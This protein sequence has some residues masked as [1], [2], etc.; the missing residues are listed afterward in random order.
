MTR[1]GILKIKEIKYI[2]FIME[3]SVSTIG[4]S[5]VYEVILNESEGRFSITCT[6]GY[7]Y[8][9]AIEVNENSRGKGYSYKMI[10]FL[11]D[12]TY[13]YIFEPDER[14]FI[15]TDASGFNFWGGKL[16]MDNTYDE[17][18]YENG[19]TFKKLRRVVNKK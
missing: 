4:T 3:Y 6:P 2:Y 18:G 11:L 8:Q 14:V 5:T 7:P 12:N 13:I 19:I 10:K 1:E 15:D 9:M 17:N 16:E